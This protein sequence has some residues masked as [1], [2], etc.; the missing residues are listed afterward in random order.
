[1]KQIL[2]AVLVSGV[3]LAGCV[4]TT[5]FEQKQAELDA[6]NKQLAACETRAKSELTAC[7]TTH[8]ELDAK[9]VTANQ[10]LAVFRQAAEAKQ[11]KLDELQKQEE[12]L[13]DRLSKELTDKNVEIEQ[14]RGQLSVRMLDKIVFKSGSADILPQGKEVLDKLADAIKDSTD[15]IRVE[16]HT[17]DTPISDKLKVKYP[18]NWELSA[19]RASAVAR[20]FETKHFINPKRL[21]SLGFSMYH[22]IAP[23]DS[24]E[25]KQRNRRVEIVLKPTAEPEPAKEAAP[26]AAP[27]VP[28]AAP[29]EKP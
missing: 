21:E 28:A 22:P 4:S 29:E 18:S 24:D 11:R 14:L 26:A 15:T 5:T 23:N 3:F 13:R 6:K 19:A 16:G 17:D 7:Q 10:E 25:N 27:A 12:H 20:Y 1:M 2:C 9:L 8:G